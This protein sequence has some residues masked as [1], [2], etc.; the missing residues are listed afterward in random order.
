LNE[1]RRYPRYV[2]DGMEIYGQVLR[3]AQVKIHN[4]SLGG[5]EIIVNKELDIG[6][7][8]VLHLIHE[9]VEIVPIKGIVKWANM[10][11]KTT[12]DSGEVVPV[13][14]VGI[15]FKGVI[16]SKGDDLLT[17][18]EQVS[19]NFTLRLKGLRV[20]FL[21]LQ[22]VVLKYP[23]HYHVKKISLGGMLIETAE[24]FS[25]DTRFPIEIL[26]PGDDEP[27]ILLGRVA[28]CSVI[29]D[30]SPKRFDIG[31]EFFEMEDKHKVTIENFIK[32]LA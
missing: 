32:S 10:T 7:E 9:G 11:G 19:N 25:V 22:E 30:K 17:F 15:E 28:S 18:I 8:Y 13:Y 21:A 29:A 5:A 27:I 16:T 31:I 2:I 12:S 24:E 20:K 4:I 6:S 26:F 14:S 1:K 23:E 3:S